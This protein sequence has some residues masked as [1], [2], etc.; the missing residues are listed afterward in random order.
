VEWRIST[1]PVERLVKWTCENSSTVYFAS[2]WTEKTGQPI[3]H[4]SEANYITVTE[5]LGQGPSRRGTRHRPQQ[6]PQQI[7]C[8]K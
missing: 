7:K 3:P 5:R 1:V 8:E 6:Q 2:F 4:G